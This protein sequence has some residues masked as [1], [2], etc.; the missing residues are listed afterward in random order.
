MADPIELPVNSW[1][2]VDLAAIVSK[3]LGADPSEVVQ[4]AIMIVLYALAAIAI[5]VVGKRWRNLDSTI[6]SQRKCSGTISWVGSLC[7]LS[8]LLFVYHHIYDA[9]LVTPIVVALISGLPAWTAKLSTPMRA[10]LVWLVAVPFWNYG[11]SETFLRRLPDQ[12]WIHAVATSS[13][14]LALLVAAVSIVFL[15]LRERVVAS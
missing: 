12:W 15:G 4:V 7:I 5:S 6:N 2:R 1:L 14:T 8:I 3:W 10:L 9:L 11:S 13:T